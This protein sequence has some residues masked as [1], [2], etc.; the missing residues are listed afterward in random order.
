MCYVWIVFAL[1]L[2]LIFLLQKSIHSLLPRQSIKVTRPTFGGQQWSEWVTNMVIK[3]LT[4]RTP[5][6]SITANI[7]TVCRLVSPNNNIVVSL[8]GI[9]FSI[10]VKAFLP[11]RLKRLDD[12]GSPRR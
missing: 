8:P 6:E 9:D 1:V 4:H 3:L 10:N 11:L 2:A 5:P 12:I 7:L